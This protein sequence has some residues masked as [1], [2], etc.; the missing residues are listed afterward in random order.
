[1]IR[2]S[3]HDAVQAAAAAQAAPFECRRGLGMSEPAS[4]SEPGW[5][6]DPW[7]HAELRWHDGSDWTSHLHGELPQPA[8]VAAVPS[9]AAVAAV[10]AAQAPDTA[11]ALAVVPDAAIMQSETCGAATAAFVTALLGVPIVP[12]VLGVRGRRAIAAAGGRLTGGWMATTGLVLGILNSIVLL[13]IL[14]AVVIPVMLL[15]SA[16]VNVQT[17][18]ASGMTGGVATA[19]ATQAQANSLQVRTAL[20]MCL[21]ESGDGSAAGCDAAALSSATPGLEPLL[22]ACGSAGGVC[23]EADAAGGYSVTATD[24]DGSKFVA[25]RGSDGTITR[26]CTGPSCPTGTW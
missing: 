4:A 17:N 13:M 7:K 9:V 25:L 6:P 18:P 11:P 3:T 22:S 15:S 21:A 20:E 2:Y 5:Y 10:P 26:T 1:L 16:E 19:G 12:I 24:R 14:L 23:V 8:A